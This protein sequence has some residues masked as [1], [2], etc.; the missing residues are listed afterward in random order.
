MLLLKIDRKAYMVSQKALPHLTLSD[1]ERSKSGSLRLRSLVSRK[2]AELGYMLL[3]NRSAEH[4]HLSYQLQVSSRTPRSMDIL[5]ITKL[6]TMN[7]FFKK[8]VFYS[9]KA[10]FLLQH[11]YKLYYRQPVSLMC[12]II[13]CHQG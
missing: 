8:K 9:G 1:I 4:C 3:S 6:L 2:G 10:L 5:F 13:H 11:A 12:E 7:D